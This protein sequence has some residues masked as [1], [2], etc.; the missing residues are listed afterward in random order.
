MNER[1]MVCMFNVLNCQNVV[2]SSVL[3][4]L[5]SVCL[6]I[7]CSCVSPSVY[8]MSSCLSICLYIFIFL[9]MSTSLSAMVTFPS[10]YCLSS[11]LSAYIYLFFCICLSLRQPWSPFRLLS[12]FMSICVCLFIFLRMSLSLS[13]MVAIPSVYCPSASIYTKSIPTKTV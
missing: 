12:V 5:Y 7:H 1:C 3:D 11:C 8:C 6:P 13:A 10:V 9:R 4:L 2:S